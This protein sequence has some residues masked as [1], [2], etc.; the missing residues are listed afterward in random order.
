M[1]SEKL[2]RLIT[3][4]L[5]DGVLTDKKKQVLLKNAEAEEID[6]DEF[7]M[8]L[9]GRLY[10]QQQQKSQT[11]TTDTTNVTNSIHNLLQ[12]LNDDETKIREE[13]KTE[14]RKKEE[15]K[16]T[17][18]HKEETPV[19]ETVS[20]IGNI[21]KIAGGITGG[22]MKSAVPG[23]EVAG[24]VANSGVVASGAKLV[25]TGVNVVQ[26]FLGM[27]NNSKIEQEVII[28]KKQ[29]ISNFPIPNSADDILEFLSIAIPNAKKQGN[30]LST[31]AIHNELVPAWKTKCE[32][33]IVKAKILLD[34]EKHAK[35]LK[36]IEQYE[37]E[38]KEKADAGKKAVENGTQMAKNLF[39]IANKF[40]S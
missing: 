15:L 28:R 23:A 19:N 26:E 9:D 4:A 3:L 13:L 20:T 27:D 1:Y 14:Y 34:D 18:E 21:A 17:K 10:E 36:V 16:T 37:S 33:I 22:F 25:D 38:L 8:V 11:S 6:P 7:E 30:F 5:A 31:D 40:L 24:I 2:E 39:G 35:I 12:I 32:Q 29:I